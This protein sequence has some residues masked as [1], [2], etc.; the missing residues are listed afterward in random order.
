M[1]GDGPNVP[2]GKPKPLGIILAGEDGLAV[3]AVGCTIIGIDPWDVTHLRL[4]AERGLGTIDL[5]EI[6]VLGEP[7]EKIMNPFKKPTLKNS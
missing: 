6:K 4:A 5:D 2:K 1:E 7:I 3:D